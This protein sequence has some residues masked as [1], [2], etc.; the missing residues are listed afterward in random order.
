VRGTRVLAV[1][2]SNISK[3]CYDF[4]KVKLNY[5]DI[6]SPLE[7]APCSIKGYNNALIYFL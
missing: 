2:E 3:K 7:F 1:K 4:S 6:E 5:I